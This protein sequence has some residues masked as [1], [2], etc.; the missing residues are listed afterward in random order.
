MRVN[1][2]FNCLRLILLKQH[3]SDR[4]CYGVLVGMATNSYFSRLIQRAMDASWLLRGRRLTD[5]Q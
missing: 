2:E 1:M 3:A 5:I 4:S